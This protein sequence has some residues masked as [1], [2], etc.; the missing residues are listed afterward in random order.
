VKIG[1]SP[2]HLW[3]GLQGKTPL[4]LHIWQ[5]VEILE[6]AVGQRFIGQ[7]PQAFGR[8]QRRRVRRQQLQVDSRRHLYLR[9]A[10]RD[11]A[12]SKVV[13]AYAHYTSGFRI[14]GGHEPHG[15]SESPGFGMRGTTS[16]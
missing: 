11:A 7:R 1:V 4:R 14:I 2:N 12:E 10:M 3:H 6:V 8:L 9:T 16:A 5:F 13:W 15:L